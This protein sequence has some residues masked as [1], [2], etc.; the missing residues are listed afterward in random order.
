MLD[1]LKGVTLASVT[2]LEKDSQRAFFTAVDGRRW[3]MLH[4]QDC[5]EHVWLEDVTGD[6]ADLVGHP[7]VEA[8]ETSN[9]NHDSQSEESTTWTFY[10]F[11]T[12]KGTV[13]LRWCGQSNGYYS[14]SVQFQRVEY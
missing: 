10:R 6:V 1:E 11:S 13:T 8:S 12:V 2:G 5:C 9:S 4:E 3:V 14:E 7:I